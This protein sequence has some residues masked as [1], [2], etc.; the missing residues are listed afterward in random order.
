MKANFSLY[1]NL[2]NGV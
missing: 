1:P 2:K